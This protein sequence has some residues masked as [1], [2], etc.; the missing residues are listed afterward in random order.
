MACRLR[1]RLLSAGT[2]ACMHTEEAYDDDVSVAL[3]D[4]KYGWHVAC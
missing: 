4:G 3:E 2:K 1:V